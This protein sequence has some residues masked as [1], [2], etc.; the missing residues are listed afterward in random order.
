MNSKTAGKITSSIASIGRCRL[1]MGYLQALLSSLQ[2]VCP[3]RIPPTKSLEWKQR[4]LFLR[5]L[6][7]TE[8]GLLWLEEEAV[9]PPPPPPMVLLLE[10]EEESSERELPSIEIKIHVVM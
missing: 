3:L 2:M 6:L 9:P 10:E 7:L 8:M 5:V 1:H 4:R